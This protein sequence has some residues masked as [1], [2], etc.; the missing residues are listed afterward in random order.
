MPRK[1]GHLILNWTC[2]Q[3]WALVGYTLE[4]CEGISSAVDLCAQIADRMPEPVK[5]EVNAVD[6]FRR[7]VVVPQCLLNIPDLLESIWR[8][9]PAR[10][11][12]LLGEHP[13]AFWEQVRPD[14]PRLCSM[15]DVTCVENWQDVC[16]PVVLHGDGGVYTKKTQ[17]SILTVS[18]K[19]LLVPSFSNNVIPAFVLPKHIRCFDKG[20]M[21]A[22]DT[23]LDTAN[24]MWGKL[25][26]MLNTCYDGICGLTVRLVIWVIAGDLE[27]SQMS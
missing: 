1:L 24:E 19:S 26:Q 10:F 21:S 3:T 17:S 7:P 8:H 27:F 11:K 20:D 13:R 15:T 6:K 2:L 23:P 16:Y 9:H 14:D 25:I 12:E 22:L 18:M 5:V 4:T